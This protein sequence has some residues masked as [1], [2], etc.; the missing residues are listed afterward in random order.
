[1]TWVSSV[2]LALTPAGLLPRGAPSV[3]VHEVA[4]WLLPRS[5]PC[6]LAPVPQETLSWAPKPFQAARLGDESNSFLWAI[7]NSY[8]CTHHSFRGKKAG[9]QQRLAKPCMQSEL[10]SSQAQ[11]WARPPLTQGAHWPTCPHPSQSWTSEA[12]GDRRRGIKTSTHHQKNTHCKI[13]DGI[14]ELK[15]PDTCIVFFSGTLH[16]QGLKNCFEE[17]R[18]VLCFFNPSSYL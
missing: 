17:G 16:M 3:S 10:D 6:S 1:M 4:P 5:G 8:F 11:S 9:K 2:L 18:F 7:L 14:F 13:L 12:Q 15:N